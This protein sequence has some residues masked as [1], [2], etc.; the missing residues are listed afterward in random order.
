MFI[1]SESHL[2]KQNGAA[3]LIKYA[4]NFNNRNHGFHT[5]NGTHASLC[6]D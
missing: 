3:K 2:T 5:V 6:M 4:E 1:F